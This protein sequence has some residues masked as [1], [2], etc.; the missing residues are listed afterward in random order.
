MV[1]QHRGLLRN[2]EAATKRFTLYTEPSTKARMALFLMLVAAKNDSPPTLLTQVVG[3]E[4][5]RE[6]LGTVTHGCV[7]VGVSAKH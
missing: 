1:K 2:E 7:V 4:V 3:H 6:A 5:R